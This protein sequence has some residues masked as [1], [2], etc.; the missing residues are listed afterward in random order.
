MTEDRHEKVDGR[1]G[2]TDPRETIRDIHAALKGQHHKLIIP[3]DGEKS[4]EKQHA[5]RDHRRND[6]CIKGD[7]ELRDANA[8]MKS[9]GVRDFCHGKEF[10][11]CTEILASYSL[12]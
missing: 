6:A 7:Q 9:G 5:I 2:D 3:E 8:P 1:E 4:L 11:R 10:S 12:K